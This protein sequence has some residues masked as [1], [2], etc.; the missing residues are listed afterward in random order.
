MKKSLWMEKSM[1]ATIALLA[2]SACSTGHVPATPPSPPTSRADTVESHPELSSWSPRITA[3]T[4]RYLI[5]DSSTVSIS[6]DTTSR[7]V[8]IKSTILY[9]LS[10]TSV[11]DSFALTS[12]IDSVAISTQLHVKG[13]SDT[14]RVS[15]FHVMISNRGRLTIKPEQGTVT[16]TGASISA[17]SRI[18]ELIISFPTSRLKTGD[19]W[20]DTAS[21][22]SCHGKIPLIQHA[23]REYELVD[24]SSCLQRSAVKVRRTVFDT[25]TGS[26]TESNNHLSANGSGTST[27]VLC[28]QRDTGALLESNTQ[29]RSDLTVVTTRGTFPFIQN[30]NTHIELR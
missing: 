4:R 24:L 14:G 13:S 5:L 22:I 23:T 19:K 17:V 1:L 27:S 11:G 2:L 7:V 28:L 18:S 9:S 30:T 8:P 16:C 29:S 3:G 20:T 15:E 10:V 26:S 25:F 21:T 12:R 6:N